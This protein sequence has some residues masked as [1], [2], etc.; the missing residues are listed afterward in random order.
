MFAKVPNIIFHQNLSIG[1]TLIHDNRQTDRHEQT[2]LKR[3][4]W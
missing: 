1:A 3:E 2:H 4:E